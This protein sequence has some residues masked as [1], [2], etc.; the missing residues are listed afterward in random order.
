M[1][2]NWST[3]AENIISN[4]I[5]YAENLSL[6]VSD[7]SGDVNFDLNSN[8][9]LLPEPVKK[10]IPMRSVSCEDS[11]AADCLKNNKRRV[12]LMV[13]ELLLKI[14]NSERKFSSAGTTGTDFNGNSSDSSNNLGFKM[15]SLLRRKYSF[16]GISEDKCQK[17]F[18]VMRAKLM[19]KTLPELKALK[20]TL[21]CNVVFVGSLLVRQLKRRDILYSRRDVQYG[22]TTAFLQA[23]SAKRS[24]YFIIFL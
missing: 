7:D 3:P 15:N 23:I 9:S 2:I 19:N 24:M 4:Q 5:D 22:I 6:E 21:E 18:D 10:Y 13:D 8:K 17:W 16:S 1:P 14:Y 12:S 20:D 11:D